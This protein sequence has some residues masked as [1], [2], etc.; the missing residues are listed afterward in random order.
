MQR[1][2]LA[3]RASPAADFLVR[4]P[5]EMGVY[6]SRMSGIRF[7]CGMLTSRLDPSSSKPFSTLAGSLYRNFSNRSRVQQETGRYSVQ[8]NGVEV[9]GVHLERFSQ[10]NALTR[11]M[12]NLAL[13]M[14]GHARC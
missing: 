13:N 1:I 5:G 14:V 2:F 3:L 4:R 10:L 11:S 7:N 12:G 8:T 9:A 6:S